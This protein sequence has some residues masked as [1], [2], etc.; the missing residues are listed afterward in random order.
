MCKFASPCKAASSAKRYLAHG[1][2]VVQCTHLLSQGVSLI[3]NIDFCRL[4]KEA[5]RFEHEHQLRIKKNAHEGLIEN[6]KYKI[7]SFSSS[8]LKFYSRS[9]FSL[10]IKR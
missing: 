5:A 8:R 2:K 10:P 3:N 6:I 4:I 9:K 7:T 1:I